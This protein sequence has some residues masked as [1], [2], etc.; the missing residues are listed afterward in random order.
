[1]TTHTRRRA[2]ARRASRLADIA[3][4]AMAGLLRPLARQGRFDPERG[5]RRLVIVQLDG[6]SRARLEEAIAEGLMPALAARLA[7]GS[8]ALSSCRS[9]LPASTPAF[10]AG[11]FYGVSPAV[12]GFVWYDRATGREVRMDRAADAAAV[13]ASLAPGRPGLLRGGTG[14]FSIFSGGAAFPHFC[15][16]GLT[17]ELAPD[18]VA[19]AGRHLGPT[20]L[21]AS[22][23]THAIATARA[24]VRVGRELG[25]GVVDGVRWTAALGRLRHEPRFL[26]H[27]T[28]VSGVLRELAVQGIL[29]DVSRGLP[30]VYADLLGFDEAA[31][32]RGPGSR[33]ARRNLASM[34]AALA[35][36]FGAVDAVP[37]LGY[38]V[39]VLSDHGHVA[40]QPFEALVGVTLP[41]FVARAARSDGARHA[42]VKLRPS[43]G[44]LGGRSLG[45][46][47]SRRAD[48]GGAVAVS[49]AGDLAHVYFLDE[50]GPVPLDAV[51]A[52]HWRVLAAL[53]AS[54]AI[55]VMA[56]RGGRRGFALV[57]GAVLDLDDPE[58]V[59]RLPHP[60]PQ[61]LAAYLSDLVALPDAGDLVVLGWRGT[62]RD[63]V[64]YAWEF[65]SHGGAAPEELS[66]FVVHPAHCAFRF[67]RVLRPAELNAF[68]EAT[69]RGDAAR[70]P[71]RRPRPPPADDAPPS[72]ELPAG[73]GPRRAQLGGEGA[74]EPPREEAP[75]P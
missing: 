28:L 69:Y 45:G 4:L 5:R 74:A 35:L 1:V 32:R 68:F 20:D 63:V 30:V 61:L 9:G 37:S 60:E 44:L 47:R 8:D 59:T 70:R 16:S 25:M 49:E 46:G 66:S 33:T 21:L 54:P 19:W 13:E 57:R 7:S 51:R 42:A 10:Q 62:G 64:A 24:L 56:A 38:D 12:P 27:R 3:A 15:L 52:R 53:A 72:P 40:T 31:H 14:Y 67:D 22:T 36:I 17:G 11:L 65:G 58:D 26:L 43:R 29:L 6:V 41:E 23:A 75:P 73:E 2:R 55:G 48:P 18:L 39:Y 34:D 50:R 71:G